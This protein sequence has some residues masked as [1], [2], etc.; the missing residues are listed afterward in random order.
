MTDIVASFGPASLVSAQNAIEQ[1]S[2]KG[3]DYSSFYRR[4]N[5]Y[6]CKIGADEG[7]GWILLRKSELAKLNSSTP[8]DLKLGDNSTA[9]SYVTIKRLAIIQAQRV[10]CT[11][12]LDPQSL[13]LVQLA[14][15]RWFLKRTSI[16]K[17][18]N[19]RETCSAGGWCDGTTKDG[20]GTPWTFLEIIEDIYTEFSSFGGFLPNY[21]FS[22]S[23]V[24]GDLPDPPENIRF[25]GVSAWDALANLCQQFGFFIRYDPL[26]G[27]IRIMKIGLAVDPEPGA[28]GDFSKGMSGAMDQSATPS[29][30]FQTKFP[31]TRKSTPRTSG[32]HLEFDSETVIGAPTI[33]SSVTVVFPTSDSDCGNFCEINSSHGW[34]YPVNV[35]TSQV[36]SEVTSGSPT[37]ETVN[38][39]AFI[40]N[41]IAGTTIILNSTKP[42]QF[43]TASSTIPSNSTDLESVALNMASAYYRSMGLQASGGNVFFGI[44]KVIPGPFVSQ[45]T[46][47]EWGDGL[48]TEIIRWPCPVGV[49]KP[50]KIFGC[51]GETE[52]VVFTIDSYDYEQ[53][54]AL[55]TIEY[56]PYN[57]DSVTNEIAG[58]GQVEVYDP[59][60]CYFNEAEAD[61]IGRWG[62]A[63]YMTPSASTD[64]YRLPIWVVIGLCCPAA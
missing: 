29:D 19:I 24:F 59:A 15:V 52:I 14:D 64:P 7:D 45:V 34:Y 58:Y 63:V 11:G 12:S 54:V 17:R 10:F 61:L 37:Q 44:K 53:G 49:A 18:Y 62:T 27:Y 25:E 22:T 40:N 48:H 20:A 36:Y 16:C 8:Y 47:R 60:G 3:I 23:Y 51:S 50:L 41:A 38:A 2:E 13:Y 9:D 43:D 5:S 30:D 28:D 55:C 26:S 6:T 57:V 42:A 33:P 46:W 21:T 4:A 56:R 35:T 31:L 32:D 39:M 1:F